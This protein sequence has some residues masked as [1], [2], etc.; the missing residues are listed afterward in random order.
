MA[1]LVIFSVHVAGLILPGSSAVAVALPAAQRLFTV[2]SPIQCV[3]PEHKQPAKLHPKT[4]SRVRI[5][6]LMVI[7]LTVE[8]KIKKLLLPK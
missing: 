2:L 5:I 4:M 6:F 7:L 1:T 8:Y 3:K